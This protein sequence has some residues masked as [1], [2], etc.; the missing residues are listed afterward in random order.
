MDV[1]LLVGSQL[2]DRDLFSFLVLQTRT[3]QYVFVIGSKIRFEFF[4]EWIYRHIS[5]TL[6]RK[7][8]EQWD[9]SFWSHAQSIRVGANRPLEA[10]LTVSCE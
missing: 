9:L 4:T 8:G 6:Q 10:I 2:V 1:R 5:I 7:L 3:I